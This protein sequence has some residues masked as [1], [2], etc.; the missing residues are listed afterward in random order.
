VDVLI[1]HRSVGNG[2]MNAFNDDQHLLQAVLEAAEG[3]KNLLLRLALMHRGHLAHRKSLGENAVVAGS[4]EPLA[5][6]HL[7]L[8]LHVFD[9]AGAFVAQTFE[10]P[11]HAVGLGNDARRERLVGDQQHEGRHRK[12]L[13]DLARDAVRSDHRHARLDAAIAARSMIT[14][15]EADPVVLPDNV[16]GHRLRGRLFLEKSP[17]IARGP[18]S[19][20]APADTGYPS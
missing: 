7:L 6:I 20:A 5:L 12:N 9:L 8:V 2:S 10:R 16:R 14:T 1:R 3:D 13:G 15:L 11:V 19:K 18:P 4:V 17:G